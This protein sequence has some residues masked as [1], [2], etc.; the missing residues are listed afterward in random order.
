[1]KFIENYKSTS[2]DLRK[3]SIK[4]KYIIIHYTAM[5]SHVEAIKHLCNKNN[6]V[7]SHFLISKAGDIFNLVNIDFRAWH[8]GKCFWKKESDIN[9]SSIGIELDNSGHFLDFENFSILQIN[10]LIK[11]IKHLKKNYKI[12]PQNILGHSDIA[13]YRK[14]DP[15]EKFPW[16]KL[17]NKN[18]SFFPI[19]LSISRSRIIDKKLNKLPVSCIKNYALYMLEAIGYDTSLGSNAN[20]YFKML[21]KSYQM[22]YLSK[23]VNGILDNKTYEMIKA[24][25]NEVLTN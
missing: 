15:G 20:K 2:F 12:E 7:S 1:M 22:R 18:I 11:L 23:D 17:S 25:Y 3:S 5:K 21:I 9:S 13:P 24:H 8:A 10:S 16:K 6:K 4:I 14:F 19:K